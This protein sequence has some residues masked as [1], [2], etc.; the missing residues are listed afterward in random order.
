MVNDTRKQ[1]DHTE[2]I[3][4][5]LIIFNHAAVPPLAKTSKAVACL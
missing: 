2:T 4:K 1:V 5:K 3:H